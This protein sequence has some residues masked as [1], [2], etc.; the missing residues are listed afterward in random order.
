MKLRMLSKKT[1]AYSEEHREILEAF[2]IPHE[3]DYFLQYGLKMQYYNYT[4]DHFV[5][6]AKD[7]F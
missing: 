5:W 4:T 7:L 6:P 2:F 3:I 1:K